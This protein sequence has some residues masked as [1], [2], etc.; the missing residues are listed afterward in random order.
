MEP[1]RTYSKREIIMICEDRGFT[2][3][4]IG[5]FLNFY[6]DMAVGYTVEMVDQIEYSVNGGVMLRNHPDMYQ[7][8]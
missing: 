7:E 5:Q 8:L 2:P 1:K 6:G 4:Q 3:W